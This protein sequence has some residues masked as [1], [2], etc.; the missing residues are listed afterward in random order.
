MTA[1]ARAQDEA[2]ERAASRSPGYV[3]PEDNTPNRP[4]RVTTVRPDYP[5]MTAERMRDLQ[6]LVFTHIAY[7][8]PDLEG[9]DTDVTHRSPAIRQAIERARVEHEAAFI[10]E[11]DVTPP[12][13]EDEGYY[14]ARINYGSIERR[15][16][17]D[18]YGVQLHDAAMI[19]ADHGHR[20]RTFD[21]RGFT[22]TLAPTSR[23]R[24]VVKEIEEAQRLGRLAPGSY[25]ADYPRETPRCVL[26][27]ADLATRH[28]SLVGQPGYI[29]HYVQPR[30]AARTGYPT[31][32]WVALE[33]LFEAGA[34]RELAGKVPAGETWAGVSRVLGAM[35]DGLD[36]SGFRARYEANLPGKEASPAVVA[37]RIVAA[38]A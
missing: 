22:E 30:L 2:R 6:P 7:R 11:F 17:H 20:I 13:P 36:L 19:F 26:G 14:S 23:S 38:M 31:A 33:C 32:F 35:R 5:R 9:G 10:R 37:Q 4:V 12:R 18:V 3:W 27:W 25:A 15:I 16:I 28:V 8:Q 29:H 34:R 21:L 24:E 1:R